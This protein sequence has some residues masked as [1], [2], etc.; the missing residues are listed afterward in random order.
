MNSQTLPACQGIL[1][2]FGGT[3]DSDGEH[4]LDRFL[5]LY[6]RVELEV[7]QADIKRVFY[8]ADE[9]CNGNPGLAT[10]GLR[11]LM[12]HHV[13]LQFE[14]L[15]IAEDARKSALIE[16]FCSHTEAILRR[17]AVL[18][19]GLAKK[20]RM[21]V[22]S[23]FYGNVAALCHEA[24]LAGVLSC[25]LDSSV[26]G[27]WKPDPAIFRL[28]LNLL[29]LS[30]EQVLFVGDSL[31]RDILPARSLGMRTLWMRGPKPRVPA[32][33]DFEPLWISSLPQIE[34]FLA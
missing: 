25:I 5:D 30:P 10:F 22:V 3:L 12:N 21:G 14:L 13:Q 34:A 11:A 26:V 4:W 29:E 16:G 24:G 15:G 20:Y 28:A 7:S 33:L 19:S 31:E 17:N 8:A 9:A 32:N 2:D 23:N 1:F 18:L 6:A 27:A